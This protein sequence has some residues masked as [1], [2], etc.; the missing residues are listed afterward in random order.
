MSRTLRSLDSDLEARVAGAVRAE[1]GARMAGMEER[2]AQRFQMSVCCGQCVCGGGVPKQNAGSEPIDRGHSWLGDTSSDRDESAD[3]SRA[4]AAGAPPK[5]R[6]LDAR[7]HP[8]T[9]KLRHSFLRRFART[10]ADSTA[11]NGGGS[12]AGKAPGWVSRLLE[13]VF[14]I[15]ESDPKVGKE[16]SKVIHPQSHFH[17]GLQAVKD[18]PRKI[19][20]CLPAL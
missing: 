11:S 10:E 20:N 3:R 4:A 1:L 18:A 15:C 6:T 8:T 17:T 7:K 13:T 19:K 16:G 5:V 14:G 2:I 9:G 12:Y